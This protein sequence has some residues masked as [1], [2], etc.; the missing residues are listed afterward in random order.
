MELRTPL[1]YLFV[2]DSEQHEHSRA[3]WSE[4]APGWDRHSDYMW[5]TTK[6][7][8]S[9]LVDRAEVREGDVVLEIAGGPG[10]VGMLAAEKV[11]PGGRVLGTDFSP[12]MVEVT[13]RRAAE[14]GL[15]NLE[16]RVLDAEA[17]DLADDSVDAVICRWGFM[18]MFRPEVALQECRRVLK[19]G[20]ALSFSVW[21]GPQDNLWVTIPGMVMTQMGY[22]PGGDPFGPGGMFS[23]SDH[24]RIRELATSAGFQEVQVEEMPVDWTFSSSDE[25]WTY[26]TEVAG[27]LAAL[28][29][30]LPDDEVARFREALDEQQQHFMTPEGLKLPGKTVNVV[31]R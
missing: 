6:H 11:G 27:A 14:R 7:V 12:E 2:M 29:R 22:P 16:A 25:A 3:V 5:E 30:T 1:A 19:E 17:M 21:G 23:M 26:T 24:E 15:E 13:Q 20:R 10:H 4:M 18:L 28:V 8:A 31:A 9:W